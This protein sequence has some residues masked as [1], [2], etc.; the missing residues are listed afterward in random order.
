MK[1]FK[2]FWEKRKITVFV[3]LFSPLP[4]KLNQWYSYPLLKFL[5]LLHTST[6]LTFA[7]VSFRAGTR[8]V[9]R[10]CIVWYNH[11]NLK[12]KASFWILDVMIWANIVQIFFWKQLQNKKILWWDDT[13]HP[14][15]RVWFWRCGVRVRSKWKPHP[16][17]RLGAVL[18]K[19]APDNKIL[20]NLI[21]FYVHF[22]EEIYI[23]TIYIWK[24]YPILCIYNEKITNFI[25]F[26]SLYRVF[27]FVWNVRIA[28]L[29][30]FTIR[31]AKTYFA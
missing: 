2:I 20:F 23:F 22:V 15:V 10:R 27:T 6:A 25:K 1:H 26:T 7:K 28:R 18:I 24:R 4:T 21:V 17:E 14:E 8:R 31:I 11:K 5:P 12:K 3:Y 30:S 9:H 16:S 29:R 19:T 13:S